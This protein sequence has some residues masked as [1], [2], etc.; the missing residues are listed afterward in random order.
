[1]KEGVLYAI[2]PYLPKEFIFI[3]DLILSETSKI[4]LLG[5]EDSNLKWEQVDDSVKVF[6]PYIYP[7]D[8]GFREAFVFR[9]DI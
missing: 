8:L 9:I 1:M 2:S 7:Q 5:L 6:I 4:T 3:N